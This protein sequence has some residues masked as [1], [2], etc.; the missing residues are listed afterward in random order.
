MSRSHTVMDGARTVVGTGVRWVSTGVLVVALLCLVGLAVGPHVLGYRTA[1]MLTGSMAPAIDP[2]DVIVGFPAP[3]DEVRVGD[4]LTYHIPVEDHRVVTH[5]VIEVLR[6]D[7]GSVAVRTQGDAND[8]ADPWT[9]TLEGDVVWKVEH[10]VPYAGSVI[11]ALRAPW[12]QTTLVYGVGSLLALSALV[13]IWRP[14]PRRDADGL[15]APQVGH[16]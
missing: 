8:G 15:S 16:A 7:D 12:L 14:A 4:V 2:G 5:R 9:A 6:G 10:V 11:Q 13:A 3:V 1:T